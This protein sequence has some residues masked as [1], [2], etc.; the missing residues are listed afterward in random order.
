MNIQKNKKTISVISVYAIIFAVYVLL[1]ALI[2][3][4]KAAVS[5]IS[6]GFTLFSVIFSLLVCVYAFD[7]KKTL[8]SKV[9]GYPIFRIGYIYFL[10]QFAVGIVFCILG[11]IIT[12]PYWLSLVIYIVLLGAALI[13][14][15]ATDNTRDFVEELDN[16]FQSE[17]IAFTLLQ[18]KVSG[19][20]D[21]CDN[22]NIKGKLEKLNEQFRFSDPVT[23]DATKEIEKNLDSMISELKSILPQK[24]DDEVLAMVKKISNTLAERNRICKINKVR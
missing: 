20:V 7:A 22:L 12:V 18:N 23:S 9:Y 8:V 19:I 11:A 2:P 3:F 21:A 1:F 17:T 10:A 5:W 4:K 6:F 15:I 16:K 24:S 13:G 14:V